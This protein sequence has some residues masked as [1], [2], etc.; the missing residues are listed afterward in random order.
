MALCETDPSVIVLY[1]SILLAETIY[2]SVA[3][4]NTNKLRFEEHQ[5]SVLDLT[6]EIEKAILRY[7]DWVQGRD[8]LAYLVYLK[9]ELQQ[10]KN[11]IWYNKT[12]QQSKQTFDRD[13]R[14]M[15]AILQQLKS[16]FRF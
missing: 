4:P 13:H 7:N 2:E 11:T 12:L 16:C 8:K 6:S 15:Y 3:D 14:K 5:F 1:R 10:Y 9:S